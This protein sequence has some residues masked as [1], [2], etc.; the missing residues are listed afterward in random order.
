VGHLR[1][2][3][4]VTANGLFKVFNAVCKVGVEFK[5]NCVV[6]FSPVEG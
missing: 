5:G 6:P 3:E 2:A 4:F 1:S